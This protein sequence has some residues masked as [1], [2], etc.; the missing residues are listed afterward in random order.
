MENSVNKLSKTLTNES[1][2]DVGPHITAVRQNSRKKNS[3]SFKE[4]QQ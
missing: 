2:P 4:A 1:V 3:F